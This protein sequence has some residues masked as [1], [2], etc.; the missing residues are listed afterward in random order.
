MA[1]VTMRAR[2]LAGCVA[3]ANFSECAALNAAFMAAHVEFGAQAIYFRLHFRL[4]L[5]R[6]AL[7]PNFSR[8][9]LRM[10]AFCK[11]L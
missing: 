11:Q 1:S 4:P 6:G 9:P 3:G 2:H 10:F 5:S 8:H 7:V